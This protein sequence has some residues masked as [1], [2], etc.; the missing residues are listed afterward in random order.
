MSVHPKD[1]YKQLICMLLV[2]ALVLQTLLVFECLLRR[3]LT[4]FSPC[5]VTPLQRYA[6][7]GLMSTLVATGLNTA[8]LPFQALVRVLSSL[9]RY[10][11]LGLLLLALFAVFLV[12]S[13]NSVYVYTVS[14]RIYNVSVTPFLVVMRLIAVLVD[15]IWRVVTPLFN[16]LVFFGS[17]ILKRIVV[18]LSRELV[19]DIAEIVKLLVLALVALARSC[20]VWGERLWDCTG[21]FEPRLRLCGVLANATAAPDCGS[22]FVDADSSCYASPSHLHLDLVTSGLY[23][24]SAA[25]VLQ[26][27]FAER[28]GPAALVLNL[29]IF[30]LTDYQVYLSVHALVNVVLQAVVGLYVHTMRRC[31]FVRGLDV[32]NVTKVVACTPDFE[33]LFDLATTALQSLGLAMDAW[34]N[35]AA[36]QLSAALGGRQPTCNGESLDAVGGVQLRL[37]DVVLDAARAIEGRT[38]EDIELLAGRGG[39]P[40]S[41]T[42][43]KVRV[44]GLTARMIAV[45]DGL[46][47]L[48]RSVYDGTV[49]AY[50]AFPYSVDVRAGLAAVPYTMHEVGEADP[51]GD[52]STGL[53]GCTCRDSTA[54]IVLHCATAPY[55]S[56]V[57]D[58]EA[59]FN[60][61][62]SH[63]V[64]FPGLSLLGTTCSTTSVRVLPLRWPRARLARAGS[65]GQG[66]PAGGFSGYTRPS[67]VS[68]G[69]DWRDFFTG[70]EDAVD[71]LRAHANVRRA[72]RVNGVVAAIY[73]TPA[74]GGGGGA[75]LRCGLVDDNCFPYCLGL[76]KAGM[77]SQNI[78]MHNAKRWSESVVLPDADCGLGRDRGE[79][80]DDSNPAGLPLVE[81]AGA[82]RRA[83]CASACTPSAVASSVWPLP[84][85]ADA[86]NGTL[87]RV[88]QHNAVFGAVRSREQPFV[89]AGDAMLVRLAERGETR[90]AV[91][92]LY[93]VGRASMQM[94]GERLT[95]VVNAHAPLLEECPVQ[96]DAACVA[97]AMMRGSVVPP[98]GFMQVGVA[99]VQAE[100]SVL[101]AASSRFAVHFAMNP[102]LDVFTGYFDFC[103]GDAAT[104]AF[105]VTSSYGRA[106]VWTVQTMRAVDLE[107]G[108]APTES[109]VASRVSYMR[110][111]DFFEPGRNR[112]SCDVIVGLRIV[113][114]EFLNSENVLVT[115]LAGRPSDYD[116]RLGDLRGPRH[117]RY[118]FLHPQRHDCFEP[119]ESLERGF[120]CWR[121]ESAGQFPDDRLISDPVGSNLCPE[122]R[123]LPAFGTAAV[124]P[125]VAAAAA[126]EMV[127]N[128]VCALIA[129]AV[130][131]PNNPAAA[132]LELLTLD[133]EQ[134]TFHG[135]LDSGGARLFDVDPFLGA[136][137][138]M[139][140]FLAGLM[141]YSVDA[142]LATT[143]LAGG[144][145]VGDK[146]AGGLRTLVVGTARVRQGS[147]LDLPPFAQVE[148][149]FRAPVEQVSSQA[150]IAVLTSTDGVG[151]FSLPGAVRVFVRAQIGMASQAELVLRLGRAMAIRLIEAAAVLSAAPPSA[152]TLSFLNTQTLSSL[153]GV[154]SSALVDARG[155]IESTFLD[156]LR[157]QCHGL[158]IAGGWEGP[159]VQALFQSCMVLPDTL[160]GCLSAFMVFVS[161][162]PA[163]ACVCRQGQGE[164]ASGLE[165]ATELA[166]MCLAHENALTEHAWVQ[167]MVFVIAPG[168]RN[169]ACFAAMDGANV[170]LRNA[171]DK[172]LRRL[173]LVGRHAGQAAD[174]ALALLTGDSVA[175]DAFD[176]SPYV[177]SIVPEPIDYFMHCSD[178]EDCRTRCFDEFSAFEAENRSLAG[179][180]GVRPAI[181]EE[182]IVPVESMLFSVEDLADGLAV[183]PF[184]VQ[185]AAELSPDSCAVV[186]GAQTAL[187]QPFMNRCLAVAGVRRERSGEALPA[188]AY[189]CLPID[190]MQ[191]VRKW[192]PAVSAD[193]EIHGVQLNSTAERL[194]EVRLLTIWAPGAR[195][196]VFPSDALLVVLG[197]GQGRLYGRQG[198]R[199]VLL[200]AGRPARVLLRTRR[201]SD[202][203][204]PLADIDAAQVFSE[205]WLS[206][207]ERV[208][209]VPAAAPD[210]AATIYVFGHHEYVFP[211]SPA[212]IGKRRACLRGTFYIGE[213]GDVEVTDAWEE[214]V[215]VSAAGF[216][217]AREYEHAAGG[218][219]WEAALGHFSVCV[220]P[221]SEELEAS[222]CALTLSVPHTRPKSGSAELR[223]SG[224]SM[225][226]GVAA[227]ESLLSALQVD[228][229]MPTYLDVDGQTHLRVAMLAGVHYSSQAELA[230][231]LAGERRTLSL[232]MLNGRD[233]GAWLHVL[234]VSI[235]EKGAPAATARARQRESLRA[236]TRVSVLMECSLQNCAACGQTPDRRRLPQLE[237]LE[238]TC[239][240]A[241][242]PPQP[243]LLH[244]GPRTPRDPRT[245]R[246]PPRAAFS[247][248]RGSA[249]RAGPGRPCPDAHKYESRARH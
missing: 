99:G 207:L 162:Y 81:V 69:R 230:A 144:G 33:P 134:A 198:V 67:L 216:D 151:G 214:C 44:V 124:I 7:A 234:E 89:V 12:V 113:G 133:L 170:R 192:T 175:C 23:M 218:L 131:R 120:T 17:E 43:T 96:S 63:R 246:T 100:D 158:G 47:V 30:P 121:D 21:G 168:D 138:W 82:L 215:K 179:R 59:A 1:I 190:M 9:S 11:V 240:A 166:R 159:I 209:V 57:E 85:A 217:D 228:R 107:G 139:G 129:A 147:P 71:S 20:L 203:A 60:A 181:R 122:Q 40:R 143:G 161:D 103:N 74:C 167:E 84:P 54:G 213:L 222:A 229:N 142:F 76:V 157:S 52:R 64:S 169:G 173:Y 73:V 3:L 79:Q 80:C 5:R 75:H 53:L 237:E 29:A 242:V 206:S 22:V 86:G 221:Q 244:R 115:V 77:R 177:L 25:R 92:R 227:A 10:V 28:C 114:V 61:T 51:F 55:I 245:P 105:E 38:I 90:L 14:V 45:T 156:G 204:T 94:A 248:G 66:V 197:D 102:E 56:H 155:L 187:L 199:L 42:L 62:A 186:C 191:Y 163:A 26:T 27:T 153:G 13:P 49:F 205:A 112:R 127:L 41:E 123:P 208:E 46:N 132:V 178:T 223:V 211:K 247:C 149:L 188:S 236:E 202:P 6:N 200:R 135:M 50:G 119:T 117:Y 78:S 183:P 152:K 48:Y 193:Y 87:L 109:E 32:S 220:R 104:T 19:V 189:Y 83:R 93:D 24:R 150:S 233:A 39:L 225:A 4:V 136:M 16:G 160:E 101:P 243:R 238:N 116:P 241:Q 128:S 8:T 148:N 224:G 195:S 70:D 2:S 72:A 98:R 164:F 231:L 91:V 226:Y 201:G 18:P 97:A 37:E 194:L 232:L 182:V 36:L 65:H 212:L 154:M 88:A 108:G 180:G 58:D 118:Y 249:R 34:L 239:Y 145:R 210:E 15:V 95:S 126:L 185:D 171:F 111:P 130:A 176:V 184:N 196:A 106:R 141:I 137:R 165:Q 219:E 125:V 172:A 68:T 146:T 140:S 31:H 35:F 110:I 235:P 174:S